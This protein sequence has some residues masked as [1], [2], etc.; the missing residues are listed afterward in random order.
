MTIK[1]E[2]TQEERMTLAKVIEAD[3]FGNCCPYYKDISFIHSEGDMYHIYFRLNEVA[4]MHPIDHETYH[5]LA[6]DVNQEIEQELASLKTE[7]PLFN[8]S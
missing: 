4:V 6:N 1:L 8:V 2:F 5:R 3:S 7:W